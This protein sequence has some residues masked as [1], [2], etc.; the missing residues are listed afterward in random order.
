MVNK[1]FLEG[2][3]KD[4]TDNVKTNISEKKGECQIFCSLDAAEY[5]LS[6]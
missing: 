3:C 4:I 2:G 6:Q 1:Y 5:A